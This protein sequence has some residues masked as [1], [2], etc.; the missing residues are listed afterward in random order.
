MW[1]FDTSLFRHVLHLKSGESIPCQ[2]SSYDEMTVGFQSPFIGAHLIDSADVKALEFSGRTHANYMDGARAT[3]SRPSYIVFG[4]G[5]GHVNIQIREVVKEG[6]PMENVVILDPD[7]LEMKEGKVIIMMDGKKVE[8]RPDQNWAELLP[9][10]DESKDHKL[11]VK[12]ERALTVPRFNRDTPPNHILVAENGDMKRGKLL[13]FNGETIQFDSKLRQ[14]SVP[15][16]RVARVVDVSVNSDQPSAVGRSAESRQPITD[17][18]YEVSIRLTDGSILIFEPLEV[19]DDKLLGR[20]PIYGALTVPIDSI[21]HLYFGD[22]T[23]SF[24]A[25]FEAWVVRPAKEPQF[26]EDP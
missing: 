8:L 4:G 5:G 9:N 21:Q 10:H 19:V 13:G 11:D 16:D 7:N 24:E 3:G 2:I 26:G 22:T 12:L 17:S 14:F 25:A 23:E 15:I 20:S 18:Q 6:D 1:P